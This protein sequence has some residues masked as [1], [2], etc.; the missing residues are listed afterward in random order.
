MLD[1]VWLNTAM[2]RNGPQWTF[3]RPFQT[4]FDLLYG[5]WDQ[6]YTLGRFVEGVGAVGV[7]TSAKKKMHI[8][9]K[10]SIHYDSCK[11]A[12]FFFSF[13]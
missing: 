9:F 3:K 12:I 8:F 13:W 5:D 7:M 4:T 2:D 1:W 11:T 6:K 10:V